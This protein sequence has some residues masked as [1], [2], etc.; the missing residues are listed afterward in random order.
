MIIWR[1]GPTSK[2][3]YVTIALEISSYPFVLGIQSCPNSKMAITIQKLRW[4]KLHMFNWL[5]LWI[6]Q[7]P[8]NCVLCEQQDES[9]EHLIWNCSFTRLILLFLTTLTGNAL[10][11]IIN[12]HGPIS[13]DDVMQEM[14]SMGLR[15]LQEGRNARDCIGLE[16][17]TLST[18]IIRDMD[19]IFAPSKFKAV[20]KLQ[21]EMLVLTKLCFILINLI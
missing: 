21:I 10:W 7:V 4:N 6:M 20:H 3:I 18:L 8:A 12:T 11:Q 9:S 5:R 17:Q 16:L 2:N 1:E 14:C 19:A 15:D 13:S